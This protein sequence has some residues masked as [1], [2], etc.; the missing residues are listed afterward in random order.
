[1]ALLTLRLGLASL[2]QGCL[3]TIKKS[4]LLWTGETLSGMF[5]L[6]VGDK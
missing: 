6:V 2:N 3:W 4:R 1:M 5:G